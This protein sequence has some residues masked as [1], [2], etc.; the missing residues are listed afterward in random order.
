[1]IEHVK[2]EYSD[3]ETSTKDGIKVHF[4]DGWLLVRPSNTSPK[5]SIRCEFDTQE[6]VDE[7][8]RQTKETVNRYVTR[9]T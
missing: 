8:L 1:V 4:E 3:H 9:H 2:R 5:M 7:V 6:R